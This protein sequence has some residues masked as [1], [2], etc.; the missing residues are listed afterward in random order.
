MK[1]AIEGQKLASV[2]F[3]W[4]QGERDAKEKHGEVYGESFMGIIKQLE[5]DFGRDDVNFVIGRLG[6]GQLEGNRYPHWVMVREAQVKV[7]EDSK[8]GAWIDTDDC[9]LKGDRLH[10]TPEGYKLMGERFAERAIELIK[11]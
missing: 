9:A 3:V 8:N 4:M 7:A 2:T 6:S 11:K 10:Y 1:P 5:K